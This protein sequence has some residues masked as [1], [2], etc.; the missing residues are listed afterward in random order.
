MMIVLS[1]ARW[2]PTSAPGWAMCQIVPCSALGAF[3]ATE[4]QLSITRIRL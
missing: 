2:Q 3:G 4:A 1:V